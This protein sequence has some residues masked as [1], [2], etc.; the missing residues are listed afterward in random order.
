M[1]HPIQARESRAVKILILGLGNELLADD[2]VG[3]LAARRLREELEGQ[4]E[5]IESSLSG[6]SLIELFAG[7]QKAIVL[8]AIRTGRH[9]VGAILEFAP[10]DLGQVTAPSPHYSG[11]PEILALAQQ[12][13][14]EFPQEIKILAVE[15][16]DTTTI[17]G[18]LSELVAAAITPLVERVTSQVRLWRKQESH[19]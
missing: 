4:A 12:L 17:G 5:V 1:S 3:V 14:V 19:A 11:L 9:P 10:D 16:A 8:D 6:I 7:Y 13:E 2:G 15:T 18:S